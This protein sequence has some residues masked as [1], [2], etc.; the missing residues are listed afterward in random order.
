M[1]LN[2]NQARLT[3]GLTLTPSGGDAQLQPPP[4]F[5]LLL[6][7]SLLSEPPDS[8]SDVFIIVM[9]PPA[10][11]CEEEEEEEEEEEGKLWRKSQ[12]QA[13]RPPRLISRF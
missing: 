7:A 10:G 1:D 2:Q 8:Q 5:F 3:A 6:S 12:T 11:D 4:F 9:E 13:L